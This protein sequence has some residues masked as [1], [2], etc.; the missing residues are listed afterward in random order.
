MVVQL[1]DGAFYPLVA[2]RWQDVAVLAQRNFGII[3][4]A[5]RE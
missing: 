5:R 3:A 2:I 4:V 1:V